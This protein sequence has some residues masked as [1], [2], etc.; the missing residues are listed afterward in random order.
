MKGVALQVKGVVDVIAD[1]G[2][3]SPHVLLAG[4]GPAS[5]M[6]GGRSSSMEKWKTQLSMMVGVDR[7]R[8]QAPDK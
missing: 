5:P 1:A 2:I 6:D 4:C 8:P 3:S 7:S